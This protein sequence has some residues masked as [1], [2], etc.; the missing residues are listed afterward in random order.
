MP[1]V[2]KLKSDKTFTIP[3]TGITLKSG[4]PIESP[5]EP[6]LIITSFTSALN[7]STLGLSF[8]IYFEIY[9]SPSSFFQAYS[10]VYS[11]FISVP[12]QDAYA[13]AE[14]TVLSGTI[15]LIDKVQQL[16]V[17]ILLSQPEFADWEPTQI[18]LPN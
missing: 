10:K 2:L 3:S 6:I 16:L 12:G 11:S 14:L 18:E 5:S 7:R 9:S 1:T 13:A 17:Q 15:N 8:D 4:Q